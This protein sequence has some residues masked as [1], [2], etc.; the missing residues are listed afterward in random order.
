MSRAFSQLVLTAVAVSAGAALAHAQH[1]GPVHMSPMPVAVEVPAAGVTLPMQDVGGRPVV[2][3]RI[4]G[5]GPYRFIL[6]TGASMTVIDSELKNELKLKAVP[7]M[8]AAAPGHGPAPEIV[9]VDALRVG[10]ATLKGVT[11]ALMPLGKLLTGEQRPRGVLSASVFPGH[12]VTFDFPGRKIVLKKGALAA[13]DTSTTLAYGT[14]DLLP[15]LPLT[16]AGRET[17]VQLDTGSGYGLMLP[18]RFL[19]EL[20]LASK[21]EPGGTARVHNGEA[22][23]TKARVDGPIALGPYALELPDVSFAD[24]KALYGPPRGNI[25]YQVLREFV[26]TLDSRNR[27]VRLVR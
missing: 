24:V 6:D 10:G 21:P 19:E 27:L 9:S 13:S 23:I 11:V 8:R 25:G 2:E 4:N 20:P 22:P 7:G 15:T 5:K 12:L 16:I 1:G 14:D 18:T 17:R 3:V 26:V